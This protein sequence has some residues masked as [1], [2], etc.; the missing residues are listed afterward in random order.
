[1]DAY[2]KQMEGVEKQFK[3]LLESKV[4][5]VLKNVEVEKSKYEKA[6]GNVADLSEQIKNFAAK[7]DALKDEVNNSGKKYES[8]K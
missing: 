3:G 6:C 1:M 5:S 7:F 2:N 4:M 8:Y